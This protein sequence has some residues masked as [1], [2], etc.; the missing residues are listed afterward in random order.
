MSRPEKYGI[1]RYRD[2]IF[3]QHVQTGRYLSS[4][5]EN[6]TSEIYQKKGTVLKLVGVIVSVS[7]IT[8]LEPTSTAT[9]FSS[10]VTEQQEVACFGDDSVSDA[11]DTWRVIKFYKDNNEHDEYDYFWRIGQPFMLKHEETEYVLH[12]HN[13]EIEVDRNEVTGFR[14]NDDE[15]SKWII[16]E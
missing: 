1:V 11:N 16:L 15:N 2:L 12:S 7:N 3:P 8:L 5:H 9:F 13:I 14:E 4:V 6:Y 10:P